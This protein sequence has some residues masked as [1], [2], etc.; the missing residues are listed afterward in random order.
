[1]ASLRKKPE[2][3]A[4]AAETP[5][6]LEIDIAADATSPSTPAPAPPP[7]PPTSSQ[8][9]AQQAL[10]AQL[11]ALRESE[12]LQQQHQQ[13]LAAAEERRQ[14]W[15]AGNSLAQQHYG[16]LAGFHNEAMQSGLAD[17]SPA[18]FNF[19]QDQLAALQSEDPA[20]NAHMIAEE[21]QA[22]AAERAEPQAPAPPSRSCIVS[23][24]VSRG[25]PSSTP[26][27]ATGKITL[28]PAEREAARLSGISEVEYAKHRLRLN[29]M[30]ASGE[31]AD[32]R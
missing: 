2:V 26:G 10:L 16:H 1:M 32:R 12:G 14:A 18:Y 13:A 8:N 11:D 21:L 17:S 19:M 23:A 24:P 31:Y 25:V 9:E 7:E 20:A 15:L 27:W 29:A 5:P 30:K 22:R 28:T 4:A 3:L 6:A